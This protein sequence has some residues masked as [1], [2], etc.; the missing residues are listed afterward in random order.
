MIREV[1][2]IGPNLTTVMLSAIS[3]ALGIV[4]L[5]RSELSYRE[6]SQVKARVDENSTRLTRLEN[7]K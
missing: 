5:V 3:L 7:G 4:S 6:S 1:L 2:E